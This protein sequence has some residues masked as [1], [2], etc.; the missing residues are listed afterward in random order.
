[1]SLINALLETYDSAIESKLVDNPD[2]SPG[3]VTLLPIYHSNKRSGGQDIFELIIDKNSNAINGSFINKDEYVI[4]PITEDSIIRSGSKVAPHA[5]SDELSYLAKDIDT[6]K[7][8]EYLKGIQSLLEYE[9]ENNNENFRILGKYIT[10]NIIKEDF[11][12]FYFGNAEYYVDENYKLT[13]EEIDDNGKNKKKTLDLKKV[14]VTFKL[15]KEFSGDVSLTKD[16][17]LHKFYIEY[18]QKR[19]SMSKELSYCDVTGKI[20]YCIERHRGIVGTAK[21]I[22]I[23]NH[24]ET[25]FGRLKN[26]SDIYH[27]SYEASQKIHNMLKFLMDSK[28]HCRY[29]GEG[30]HMINWL[31]QDLEKGS[32]DLLSNISDDEDFE[33]EEESTL[34]S[35]GGGVSSKLGK[36]F[37]GEDGTYDVQGNFYVLI[38]EKISNGRVSVKYFRRVSRSDAYKRVKQWYRS[39]S[40]RFYDYNLKKFINK[41]PSLQQIVDFVYGEENNKGRLECKNKKLRRGTIERIIPCIMDSQRLP[42]DIARTTFYKLSNKY[43]YKTNWNIA[44]NIGCSMIK[45]Y[46]NDYLDYLMDVD[47]ISEVEQLKESRSFFYGKLMAIYEK[48]ELDAVKGRGTEGNSQKITNSDKLWSS[49]IRTPERTRFIIESKIKPY[50]NMLKKNRPGSYVFYDKLITTITLD[51]ME[52]EEAGSDK[53]KSLNEDFILGYYYQKDQFYKKKEVK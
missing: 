43:S 11:L 37:L 26:G 20:D 3:G 14:V 38:I 49:M 36:Y 9:R 52:L 6:D 40:W 17:E 25:Y 1:M 32:A 5:V 19:N 39:T 7:N 41:S 27:V 21:L 31:S 35:L 47:N 51:I 8:E 33:E 44:L 42:R 46:K 15:E 28:E 12:R 34:A 50:M 24:N 22:S 53:N 10:K 13:Y 4:F 2:L 30:A 23:S 29:I 45:K 18:I 48:I 16:V